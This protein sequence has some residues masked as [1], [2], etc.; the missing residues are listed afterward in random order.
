MA[1]TSSTAVECCSVGITDNDVLL[2]E[3][4]QQDEEYTWDSVTMMCTYTTFRLDSMD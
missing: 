2:I 4:C 3:A 1:D